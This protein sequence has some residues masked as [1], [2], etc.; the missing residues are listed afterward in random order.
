MG[1]NSSPTLAYLICEYYERKIPRNIPANRLHRMF[2]ARFVD[3]ILVVQ[4]RPENDEIMD[5]QMKHDLLLITDTNRKG[6]IYHRNLTIKPED[7]SNGANCLGSLIYIDTTTG[8]LKIRYKNKNESSLE[9]W[10]QD[11]LP[12]CPFL[13]T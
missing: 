1:S 12:T 11:I 6:S 9:T 7:I 13:C 2:G 3:D 4:I 10:N 8:L 5:L